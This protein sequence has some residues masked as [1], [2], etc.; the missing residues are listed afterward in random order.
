MDNNIITEIDWAEIRQL[1][2][3]INRPLTDE[4]RVFAQEQDAALVGGKI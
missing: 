2:E 1:Y 4:E 3:E